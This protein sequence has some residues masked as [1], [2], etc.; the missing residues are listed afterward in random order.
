M[1]WMIGTSG[2]WERE[3]ESEKSV[4]AAWHD[5]DDDDVDDDDRW[6]ERAG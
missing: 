4:L 2:E 5:V 1:R 3:R 6:A